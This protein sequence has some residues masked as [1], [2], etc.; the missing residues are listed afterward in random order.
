MSNT[1]KTPNNVISV[2]N[3]ATSRYNATVALKGAAENLKNIE[4]AAE[5]KRTHGATMLGAVIA[6][7]TVQLQNRDGS[8]RDA[9]VAVVA[10]GDTTGGSAST[11][12]R[13]IETGGKSEAREDGVPGEIAMYGF[14]QQGD[15]TRGGIVERGHANAISNPD[16]VLAQALGVEVGA[17][18]QPT[19]DELTAI[20]E[21][22]ENAQKVAFNEPRANQVTMVP[23]GEMISELHRVA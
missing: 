1:T 8:M 10:Y 18:Y 15:D 13:V 2:N 9:N 20:A 16:E 5:S 6:E 12:L 11:L 17:G 22:V 3:P 7:K 21:G 4:G 14:S 19:V 23:M